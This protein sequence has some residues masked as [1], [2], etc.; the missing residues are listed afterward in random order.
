MYTHTQQHA[1]MQFINHVLVSVCPVSLHI[2]RVF[3]LHLSL[4]IFMSIFIPREP[5]FPTQYI[6]SF[7]LSYNISKIIS[8]LLC[9]FNY[10]KQ[11]EWGT[12]I[13]FCPGLRG[14]PVFLFLTYIFVFKIFSFLASLGECIQSCQQLLSLQ[15]RIQEYK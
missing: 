3:S 13:Q 9:P 4:Y 5:W 7:G 12:C 8:D 10:S 11:S 6:Y 2:C 15:G 14:N 1:S